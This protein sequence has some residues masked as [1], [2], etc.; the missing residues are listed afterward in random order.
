MAELRF[1]PAIFLVLLLLVA[2]PGDITDT[3]LKLAEARICRSLS[4]R[5]RGLCFSN[6]NCRNS[7]FLEHFSGGYCQGF[8]HRCFCTKQC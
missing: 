1:F 6:T 3:G 8:R 5:F 7:C 4:H 2:F